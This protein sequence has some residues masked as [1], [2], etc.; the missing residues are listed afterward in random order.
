MGEV[1]WERVVEALRVDGNWE[2]SSPRKMYFHTNFATQRQGV[3]RPLKL[4]EGPHL[5]TLIT[6]NIFIF[7]LVAV[8]RSP[9]LWDSSFKRFS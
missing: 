9:R 3:Q 6:E 2:L 4:I 1:I 7:W 5:R 8:F